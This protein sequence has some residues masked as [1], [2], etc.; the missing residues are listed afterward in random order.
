MTNVKTELRQTEYHRQ[1]DEW[2]NDFANYKYARSEGG[3]AEFNFER[4]CDGLFGNFHFVRDWIV[5]QFG[6]IYFT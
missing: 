3:N 2:S 6:K 4:C 5:L 1:I